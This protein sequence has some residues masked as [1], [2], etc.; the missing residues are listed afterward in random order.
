MRRNIYTGIQNFTHAISILLVIIASISLPTG[1]LHSAPRS[2][3]LL[4]AYAVATYIDPATGHRRTVTSNN[5][6][7]TVSQSAGVSLS[8]GTPVNNANSDNKASASVIATNT[9]NGVD[10]FDIIP[11]SPSG[12]IAQLYTDSNG[13]GNYQA[14]EPPA[15]F[16]PSIEPGQTAKFVLL[17]TAPAN[18]Q[19]LEG[20]VIVRCSSR[21][22]P[23]IADTRTVSFRFDPSNRAPELYNPVIAMEGSETR[24]GITYRDREGEMPSEGFPVL[25]INNPSETQYAGIIT[26]IRGSI[27][28]DDT[29]D[30]TP[31]QF[32]GMPVQ[33]DVP[34]VNGGIIYNVIDNTEIALFLS[35]SPLDDEVPIGSQFKLQ[36]ISLVGL[37]SD[38]KSGAV[39]QHKIPASESPRQA[40]FSVVSPQQYR[41]QTA[42]IYARYP[43]SGQL[44]IPAVAPNSNNTPPTLRDV[45]INPQTA[46]ENGSVSVSIK[47]SDANNDPP[48]Q[49]NGRNGYI[50]AVVNGYPIVLTNA[51]GTNYVQGVIYSLSL[52]NYP[53]GSHKIYF[54]ASDGE[55]V[56]R[57]PE[58]GAL[59]FRINA[60]P[61]LSAPAVSPA[62]GSEARTFNYSVI[63]TDPDGTPP[64]E[65]TLFIDSK[66]FS[67]SK[68]ALGG[69][70]FA[71]GVKYGITLRGKDIGIGEH[72]YQFSASDGIEN[73]LEVP[74]PPQPGPTVI[75]NSSPALTNGFCSRSTGTTKTPFT[76]TVVYQDADG[77]PPAYVYA[78]LSGRSPILLLPENVND[79]NFQAGVRYSAT[80]SLQPGKYAYRFETSDSLSTVSHPSNGSYLG[81][82]EVY[83]LFGTQITF[84]KN[85]YT[86]NEPCTLSGEIRPA[87]AAA[88]S[89]SLTDPEGVTRHFQVNTGADG[90][91]AIGFTPEITGPWFVFAVW[92]GNDIFE[93][94]NTSEWLLVG[95][96][97]LITS[98]MQ[99]IGIPYEPVNNNPIGVFG[100]T[101][102]FLLARWLPAE[103]R[104]A[105]FDTTGNYQSD[106]FFPE[107]T[108]GCGY[109]FGS[110]KPKLI[111]PP[112]RLVNQESE[113]TVQLHPGWNQIGNVFLK[114]TLWAN[115][116][117]R[118]DG[119]EY[120][121]AEAY[122]ARIINSYTW[123]YDGTVRSYRVLH[124]SLPGVERNLQPWRGYWVYA[125]RASELVLQPPTG[126]PEALQAS[127]AAVQ[128]ATSA[129]GDWQLRISARLKLDTPVSKD[130]TEY[131]DSDNFIG[132]AARPMG[133]IPSPVYSNGYIDLYFNDYTDTNQ[134][135]RYASDFRTA[136]RGRQ[137]WDFQVESDSAGECVITW[138]GIKSTPPNIGFYLVDLDNAFT[139][140]MRQSDKYVYRQLKGQTKRLRIV[141]GK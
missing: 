93:E 34:Q 67:L 87:M 50:W 61:S 26:D 27:I 14:D 46:V 83:A 122:D 16:S 20:D 136:A 110:Q 97:A 72:I 105:V 57:Y 31:G 121:I 120:N 11:Q 112:G 63:Y 48:A 5:A 103:S 88:I 113:F 22:D 130:I 52:E 126:E 98:G 92:E 65:I 56:T 37:S 17:V 77:D 109:W 33:I 124:P 133:N 100:G 111:L 102:P 80:V 90:R 76:F 82:I 49:I 78:V 70:N 75:R 68:D 44:N 28:I 101:P 135:A 84:D 1:V 36:Q 58:N 18:S 40:H 54:V 9:G 86:L 21:F 108:P 91:F 107:I 127:S 32:R 39:F 85:T 35:G 81:E 38:Y 115:T 24:C 3:S 60:K 47:Y 137:I 59:S 79:I 10:S 41:G 106:T 128:P 69:N 94:T 74:L 42:Y 114:P 7:V 53:V 23:S 99:M 25:W 45:E 119:L 43:E 12:W 134:S 64:K 2:G 13:D 73:A 8:I 4:T 89:V 116:K 125:W 132:I 15:S 19:V 140:D 66:P 117:V 141:T 129:I 123:T 51:S 118:L 131:S 139:L 6:V 55:A 71:S 62:I 29:A 138:D 104:Y 95:G 30:W 96:P